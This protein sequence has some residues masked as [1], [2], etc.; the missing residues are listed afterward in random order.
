MKFIPH[1]INIKR[2]AGGEDGT[3]GGGLDYNYAPIPFI[4][5]EAVATH[6]EIFYGITKIIEPLSGAIAT[7]NG[8]PEEGPYAGYWTHND[9]AAFGGDMTAPILYNGQRYHIVIEDNRSFKPPYYEFVWFGPQVKFNN[10]EH[11]F[12]IV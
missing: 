12:V 8:T 5:P 6:P 2:I 3:P 10:M 1:R 4:S 7:F 9:P 11:E